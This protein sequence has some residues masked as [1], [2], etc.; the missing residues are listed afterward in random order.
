MVIGPDV[1]RELRAGEEDDVED[2]LRAAFPGPEEAALVRALRR[3]GAMIAEFVQPWA[4]RIGAYAVVSRMVEPAGWGCLA[5]VAVWPAWQREALAPEP[6]QRRRYAP[7]TRLVSMIVA[8]VEA[9]SPRLPSRL[10][11]LGDPGF[12]GRCGFSQARAARLETPYPVDH[13]LLAGPG[14]DVPALRLVYP[15]AFASL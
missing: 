3:D 13:T 12:Y 11:V 2:L 1:T 15:A 9:G 7:G 6:R 10:V 4:G 14:T 5:P 8:A